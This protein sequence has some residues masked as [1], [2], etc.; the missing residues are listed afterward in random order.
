MR[1]LRQGSLLLMATIARAHTSPL[2]ADTAQ[3]PSRV[4]CLSVLSDSKLTCSAMGT[5]VVHNEDVVCGSQCDTR[6]FSSS[7]S[8]LPGIL[9]LSPCRE[10]A[11]SVATKDHTREGHR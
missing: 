9:P 4:Q 3:K 11:I 6:V 10:A 8:N 1:T 7:E 5:F 2:H